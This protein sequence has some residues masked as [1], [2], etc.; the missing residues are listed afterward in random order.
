MDGSRLVQS[1]LL[2]IFGDVLQSLVDLVSV[3]EDEPGGQDVL[4]SVAAQTLIH[5]A[6]F[7]QVL[8]DTPVLDY[9]GEG[10]GGL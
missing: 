10:K 8:K 4:E 3:A 5:L 9:S 6:V 7:A 1:S 2:Q